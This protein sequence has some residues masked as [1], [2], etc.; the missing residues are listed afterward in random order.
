[1]TAILKNGP[2]DG[3]RIIRLSECTR[4]F[5]RHPAGQHARYKATGRIEFTC[6]TVRCG[7]RHAGTPNRSTQTG[8]WYQTASYEKRR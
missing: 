3:E 7:L 2:C 1:M 6:A 5:W 8:R 4:S